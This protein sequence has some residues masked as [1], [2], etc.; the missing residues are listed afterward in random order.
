MAFYSYKTFFRNLKL[1][2]AIAKTDAISVKKNRINE[3]S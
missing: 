2:A 1:E 3:T